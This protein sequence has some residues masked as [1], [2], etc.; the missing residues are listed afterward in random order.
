[1]NI[2]KYLQ[3]QGVGSRKQCQILLNEQ[4]IRLNGKPPEEEVD[5]SVSHQLT[6][7][8]DNWQTMPLPYFYI[9]MNK[10][11]NYETSHKPQ[12]YP[13]VFSLLP[14]H[15]RQ[16]I[17]AIGRLDADTTGVLILTN[18]GKLNHF[19][20]S[21]KNHVPKQYRITLKHSA[22]DNLCSKLCDGVLL[23]D[24]N[25]TLSAK[26]AY[27]ENEN[28][29]MMTIESGK[30]HQVKRMIASAGNRVET[31]HRV[32]FGKIDTKG[33]AIGKWCF[34]QADEIY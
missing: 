2:I 5:I 22:D 27:L 6:I 7:D 17:Q 10:P 12:H 11:A 24:E 14:S 26:D 8:E 18:D 23:H 28:T 30:Y 21:A 4:R 29:L 16:T 9:L 19:L 32:R 34:I 25:E 33:L 31:L 3:A 20:T 1:M 13:S 15:F